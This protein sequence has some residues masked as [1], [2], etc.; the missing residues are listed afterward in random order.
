[1]LRRSSPFGRT[2]PGIAVV[3]LLTLFAPFLAFQPATAA[4]GDP[5]EPVLVQFEKD[6]IPAA[7]DAAVAPGGTVTYQF[8]INC[9]SLETDC[10]DL[11]LDDVVPEPLE[12]QTVTTAQSIPPID[13]EI[14]G[15]TFSVR[16]IDDLGGGLVG[17][18]AGTG[19]QINATATV[20]ADLSADWDGAV[21]PNTATVSVANREDL[22]LDPPR[23]SS[24]ES[25]AEVRLEVERTLASQVT[26]T[27]T[28]DSATAV[29]GTPVAIALGATNSSNG[30]VDSLVVQEPA[31]T[32]STV[33]SLLQP[34]GFSGLTMPSGADRVRVDW[35]DGSVWSQ[36]TAAP[37]ASLPSGVDAAD[38]RALRLVFTSST[39]G[40]IAVGATAAITLDTELSAT[41]ALVTE[42]TTIVN[43]A[44]S[45]VVA[46]SEST[47]P[48]QATD[49]IVIGPPSIRP[50]ATKQFDVNSI[51]GG[52][53]VLATLGGSNGGDF[54]LRELTLTE[55]APGSTSLADQGLSFTSWVQADI[56]WPVG[57]TS[58]EVSYRYAGDTEFA[59]A[60]V[61][62][63]ADSLPEP[64]D[65]ALVTDIRVRFLSTLPQ[66]MAPGQY[67]VLPFL[68]MTDAVVSD[69]TESNTVRVDV[70]TLADAIASAEA[71]D[72]LTR[73]TSRVNTS[74][75][76]TALPDELYAIAGATTLIS[77]PARVTPLP[78]AAVDPTA[79]TVG[80]T[81]LVITDPLDAST[82]EFWNW[83]D[84]TAI[85][86]TAV[87]GSTVLSVEYFDGTDWLPLPGATDVAGPSFLSTTID[88]ALRESIEGV[89]FTYRHADYDTLGTLLNPGFSAQPNLSV[90]LRDQLRDGTGEAA[91]STRLEAVV[92]ANA[93]QSRVANPTA[94]PVEAT[95]DAAESITL[96]PTATEGGDGSGNVT[97]ISKTWLP[98]AST[99]TQAVNARSADEATVEISW[100]TGGAAFDSVVISD[101]ASDPATTPVA[102]TVFEAFDLVRIPAIT[103]AM[104]P[105][106][107]YDRVVA[108]ELYL[109]GSGWTAASGNPCAGSACDGTFPGYTLS[110]SE[111]ANATGVR[112]VV[113]ES[114]TRAAR[115]GSTPTAPPVGT[116]V[117]PSMSLSRDLRLVFEVRDV[118]RSDP[119]TAVLG[120]T[121]LAEYN[122]P[123]QVGQ[124][125][126]TA[127]M[128]GRD[129][130]GAVLLSRTAADDILILD[131]PLTVEI[132]KTWVDGPLG[133]PP[134][135][136]P[137]SLYPRARMTVQATNESV[138]RVDELAIV[139][140][141]AGTDPFDA[142]N[143][144]DIVSITVPSGATASE[145]RLTREGPSVTTHT[146]AAALALT[147]AQLA[148]VIGFEVVH[149][150][151]IDVQASTRVIVDT[152]LRPTL[153][154][155]PG[156]IVDSTSSP[157]VDNTAEARIV[158]PGGVTAPAD[159]ETL[160]TLTARDEA[161]VT[162]VDYTY[163]VTATKGIVADT[164][165]TPS[166]PATQIVGNSRVAT[167]T[168]TG[169]PSG[170]V[171]ST[172]MLFEDISPSFWNAYTF[173][174]FGSHSFSTPIN[175][176]KVDVL[177]G[178]D[179]VIDGGTG[180]IT[181]EC[182]GSTDLSACWVE[183]ALASSL[184]LP[185]LPP[186]VTVSDIRGLRAQYTRSDGAAWERP[187]NPSQT[188]R[189]T[190]T[191]RDVLVEPAG[192]PVPSTLYIYTQPAPGET[193]IGVFTNDLTVTA[194]A[195]NGVDAPLWQAT[196][197]DSKQL[198]VQHRPAK[199][200]IVKTPY[201]PLTLG[202]PVPYE[203]EVT[204]RGTGLD[205]QLTGLEV[206]DLIPVDGSGPQLVLGLDP[207]TG[208][209]FD[210]QDVVEIEVLD[211]ANAPVTAPTFTAVLGT[212]E[213]T[214][215]PLTI[216]ID[217]AFVLEHD[218]SMTI[219]AP[220]QFR[221]FFEAGSATENFVLN[222]ATVTSDQEF[223][224]C[225]PAVDGVLQATIT[226]VPSCTA[227]TRVWALPSAPMTI[228][229][230]VKGV[231]AGPL[232]LDGTALIDPETGAPYDDLGVIKT[233]AS[234]PATCEEPTLAV[235]GE[236]YYRY[237]CVPITR[238][239][240]TEEWVGYFFNAGNV[241]V[242]QISSIDVL[243]RENDR[244]VIIN[245]ARSSRWAPILLERPRL[246]GYPDQAMTVYYTDRLDMATPA[247]NGAD[248]QNDLG[249]SP[250][251]SPPM[252]ESYWPCVTSSAPG[253]LLDRQNATTGW[254]VMPAVPSTE[255]LES[256]V[257]LKFVIDFEDGGIT[258]VGLAPGESVSVAYR[259]RTAL[260]PVLRETD[261]NL[262][263]DSIAYNSIAG[264]A[265]GFDGVNDLP[266]RFVTEPRKV[267]VALATG[268]VD[269]AKVVEGAGERFAPSTFRVALACTVDIDGAGTEHEPE[270]IELLSSTGANRSPFTL[271]GDAAATRIL[272]I[273]LYAVCD[274]S[275]VG[276]TGAADTVV[277]PQEVVSRALPTSPSTVLD[278]VPAFD[279]RP[280][281][282]QST[283]TNTYD[284]ASLTI[285]KTVN[286]NGAVNEAG[287][288]VM[289][290]SFSFSVAC[291][292]D[293]GSG[294]VAV[295][296]TPSTFTLNN[297]GS[298]TY[299]D[300]P[301]GAVCTV[302]ETQTRSATVTKIVTVGGVAGSST[303][304]ATASGI[305]LAP[306][307]ELGAPTNAVDYT[308]SIAVGSL[309]VTKAIT[310]AGAAE[311]G[312]G[313]FTVRVSCT[314]SSASA[315]PATVGAPSNSVYYGLLS[316][317]AA[318][319]L[320]AT[321]DNLPAGSSC[322]ITETASAGATQVTN[323]TNVT[324]VG[325]STVSRTVTNRFDLASITVGKTVQTAA[326]DA[327]GEPVYPADPFEYEVACTF[328]SETVL[329]DDFASS[330][331][332][333]SLRHGETRTLTGLPAGA[334]CTVTETN[335]QNADSTAV[336]RTVNGTA[337][338]IDGTTVSIP[339]LA[340]DATSPVT[341][342]STQFT[343]RYG[344]SSFT[345]SKDVIG[346][347]VGQFA[348]DSF[349]AA[350][351]CETADGIVSFDSDVTVP[352]DGVTTIENLA[353]GSTCTVFERDVALTGADAHRMV[354]DEGTVI[355]GVDIVI[356]ATEPGRVTLENYYLTGELEVTKSVV[357]AGAGFGAGPFEVSLACERDGI[358]VE[359]VGGAT[360]SVSP[361]GTVSYTLLPSGAECTLTETDP[362]GATSSRLLDADGAELTDDVA[363]GTSFTVVVD[364]TVLLDDQA[365]SALEVENTF[366]LASI[367]VSKTVDSA[368]VD[369]TGAAIEF[370]PFPIAVDCLFEGSAVYGTGY[371]AETPMRSS[372]ADGATWTIDGL[373]NGALCTVTE[374]DTMD[375]GGTALVVVVDGGDPVSV[376]DATADVVLGTSS[377]VAITNS[378]PVGA[379]TLT[380]AVT[381]VGADAWADAPFQLDVVCELDDATGERT[382][383]TGSFT[384]ERGDDPIQIDDLAVGALCTV[385][386]SK[387]GGAS[388][389]SI[390]VD[391]GEPFAGLTAGVVIDEIT[392]EVTVTNRF[393]LGEVSVTKERDGAGW[394][395]WGAG[396]FEVELTCTRDIDGVEQ[397]IEVPGGAARELSSDTLYRATWTGL[398]HDAQCEAAETRTAGAT[399]ST[400]DLE[401]V[402]VGDEPV[403]FVV[404]NTFD[405][406]SVR[407]DK[408]FA[409]DAAGVYVQGPFEASLAC[410]LEID[411]VVTELDIPGGATRELT[412]TGGWS[413]RWDE[414]P[415]GADCTVTETRTGGATSVVLT[416]AEFVV[417]ADDEHVVGIENTFMLASFSITK[418][419]T[420]PFAAEGRDK[421]FIIETACTWNRD[422]VIVSMLPGG[423][424]TV[425]GETDP[426]APTSV[427]SEI[428]HGVTVTFDDLPATSVCSIDEVD[429][430]GATAQLVWMGG[431]LQAGDLTLGGGAND[432][433]LSNV[434]L[435]SLADTGVEI[436]LWLWVIASLFVVGTMLLLIARRRAEAA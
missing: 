415:A 429:S 200:Q 314:R 288:P 296:M 54:G 241:R 363:S 233:V 298:R 69:A 393:D 382:V 274:V 218:W 267:G 324:I 12:L 342:N 108:V 111:S 204:N 126:N 311:Y 104:D 368:A 384:V 196:D 291:T 192:E 253:G 195:D 261:A 77:I 281:I 158:D 186:G 327:E 340:A 289:Q 19:I 134:P 366:E 207:E 250:T 42:P 15:N 71:S 353:D 232:D 212:A 122:I 68:A 141:V 60:I 310:G 378:Y 418:A 79:S 157:I 348:P 275:E 322:A 364:D 397:S 70:V 8:T 277:S 316:F 138:S 164:T 128:Q 355:D 165:A 24:V 25:S 130:E 214:G 183:G 421:V 67:A 330:P 252:V 57:A 40:R 11:T 339:S 287:N 220:L 385:T 174:A 325:G 97:A 315:S 46:D 107:T 64:V 290:S 278:P 420:G 216:T 151:R 84:L 280:A 75:G 376:D 208:L 118:R 390:V 404:T 409:G 45:W 10:L 391:G 191:R 223:D 95:A 120:A 359:I 269:L 357:G 416:D 245:D 194:W 425:P 225:T 91:S 187:F 106:L 169:Q 254:Q 94:D 313:T 149:T 295:T 320:S 96:L 177:V 101:S 4:E 406:G 312:D 272:G 166:T 117:A 424:P 124:V 388:A 375:A 362:A 435:L 356:T 410:T 343:N 407:V 23:P 34:T 140:P 201:G 238:P 344:V 147:T 243:P 197:D 392:H 202:A 78:T 394:Q 338:S 419:V 33:L 179:Y 249:M 190:A 173:T 239:G 144:F 271:T 139:D 182:E 268:A 210:P 171:R 294:P 286:M 211:E 47:T 262:A 219:S 81:S 38:I 205:K 258:P 266:Y 427:T 73:R 129:A 13:V 102:D 301:A 110:A 132:T 283:V 222:T 417:A 137:Q 411:G 426:E 408:T 304:G 65:A 265:R 188:L 99:G 256:V 350:L 400:I 414:I 163:G 423:W 398:P 109:P 89:R 336:L 374:T 221:Q 433:T 257:A 305:V 308:N 387:T 422:G 309:T 299:T 413:A 412:D 162:V 273:P 112:L 115:I 229:K 209:T 181:V 88:P 160:V 17:L 61:T 373:P 22:A 85:V 284:E 259:T 82:D 145:V 28:P 189:F 14:T 50:V 389:T 436:M 30:S 55:P 276:T 323:P 74:I 199:V 307:T 39:G 367:S 123:G 105:L 66:G 341:R 371:A 386:E 113:Q 87:P 377:S 103:P 62:T 434:F 119:A 59:A 86:A 247:C 285:T 432:S 317:S 300:L 431:A 180:A 213:P 231:E 170:T 395:T 161:A 227:S 152:Q 235:D 18:Q 133:T 16:V 80:S 248:I 178:V 335:D 297:G 44:S 155:D 282:E 52:Q 326:V 48:V 83:F 3:A 321:I 369:E 403:G 270:P 226:E 242:H 292:Y 1:M 346:G 131:T 172:D 263:R 399:S 121:R 198:L 90:S 383:Y 351:Y 153:R 116:G 21:L 396:P 193:E 402:V 230:G 319:S 302:T 361:G 236:L 185:T 279:D 224:E 93:A 430:G 76:K 146:I 215:Q 264:A 51:I 333:F 72:D 358:A 167:V 92:I 150:G 293:T 234:N 127:L 217:P 184:A 405:V 352:A 36:G 114:P 349:T 135:G 401:S 251:S 360:R 332:A 26:K 244:G 260:E 142:V 156:T 318:T 9:S 334:A 337:T 331:M 41:A 6:A 49:S 2:L 35:F 381:G 240:G 255:L 380:K 100:G 303:S 148:D 7:A 175:R 203:I 237:P 345:I 306:D 5:D 228:I 43:T 143:L 31:D 29:A 176:V 37:T 428:A 56:E 53:Q 58:A 206:V 98:V 370:G 125:R 154:S 328:Q 159:G 347:G 168:L 372:L 32:S 27:V 20:P 329:A 63:T 354:D 365:Q 136:T 246:V 379:L